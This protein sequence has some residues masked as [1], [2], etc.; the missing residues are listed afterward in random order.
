M[1]SMLLL[2]P[3]TLGVLRYLPFHLHLASTSHLSTSYQIWVVLI[4]TVAPSTAAFYPIASGS[5]LILQS[6]PPPFTV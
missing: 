5:L 2:A 4:P 1:T 6:K 3:L